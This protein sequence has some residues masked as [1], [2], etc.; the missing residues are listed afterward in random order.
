[1]ADSSSNPLDSLFGDPDDDPLLQGDPLADAS[2]SSN[3]SSSNASSSNASESN[4]P[5]ADP[6]G[7]DPSG[8]DASDPSQSDSAAGRDRTR[9]L[10]IRLKD[11]E[12]GRLSDLNRLLDDGWKVQRLVVRRRSFS[13]QENRQSPPERT[14]SPSRILQVRLQR[15]VRNDVFW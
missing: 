6:S 2:S 5:E 8:A 13:R 4:A 7:A 14:S 11:A 10:S 12:Q 15:D 9:E 1:M 3:A